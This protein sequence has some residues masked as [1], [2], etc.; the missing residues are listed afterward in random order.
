MPS[1]PNAAAACKAFVD[2][3]LDRVNP[4]WRA[5][6]PA[7][8]LPLTVY[9]QALKSFREHGSMTAWQLAK[10][11][12][13]PLARAKQGIARAREL[14]LI[15]RLGKTPFGNRFIYGA[16]PVPGWPLP[17]PDTVRP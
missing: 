13:W 6:R 1:V 17:A 15:K 5:G 8:A 7:T 2:A 16:V 9:E 12:N 14:A 11:Q 4:D 3:T 10:R